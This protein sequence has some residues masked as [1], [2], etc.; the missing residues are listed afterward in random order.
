M[1]TLFNSSLFIRYGVMAQKKAIE[2]ATAWLLF[3][4]GQNT[5]G[6]LGDGTTTNRN[7]PTAI[8]SS[9]WKAIELGYFYSLGIRGDDKL[10]AWG[11]NTDGQLGDGTTTN[12]TSPVAIGSSTWKAISGG[13]SHSLGL[14]L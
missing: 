10:Y 2:E 8:G 14:L 3:A 7:T 9:N 5:Y 6:Q 4:W 12:R 1:N 11:L 13:N